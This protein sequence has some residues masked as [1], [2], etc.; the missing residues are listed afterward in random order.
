MEQGEVVNNGQDIDV[1]SSARLR[2]IAIVRYGSTTH[3]VD[4]DQRRIELCGP[5]A[6]ACGAGTSNTVTVPTDPG[7]AIPGAAR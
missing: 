6:G 7:V 3:A 5:V 1:T 2:I 4:T